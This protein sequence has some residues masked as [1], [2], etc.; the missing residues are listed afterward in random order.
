M[1][2]KIQ[3]PEWFLPYLE[4]K[5]YKG[6]KGGRGSG[7]SHG[8]ADLAVEEMVIDP[9][10]CFVCIREIQKSLKFSAKKLVESK[11]INHGVSH[12]FDVT[13]TEIRRIGGE[14]IMIFQGMQDHTSDSIK[15]LEGFHRAWVEEAQSL[16]ARSVE[17]L[18]PTIREDGSEVWFS[19][20]PDQETDPVEKH[21]KT[22]DDDMLLRHINY[23]DNPFLPDTLRKEME[24]FRRIDPDRFGH[25]WLGEYNTKKDSL[26]FNNKYVIDEFETDESF[27]R[28]YF[29]AD[30]G[31]SQDP[32]TMIKC[33]I[34]NNCLYITDEVWAI[35]CEITDTPE[36]FD[37]IPESRRY[38]IRA[39][40]ARPE[41]ISHVRRN[42]FD[43]I[44]AKKWKGSVED[45]I[46][47]L[48]G[49]DKIIIHP[50]CRKTAE[51]FGL[52]SYKIDRLTGDILPDII[53]KHN[54]CID[55]IRY[56][57][58]PLVARKGSGGFYSL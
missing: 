52:Y 17:L 10:L 54:H 18:L 13:Q 48:R 58:E 53:D 56:A 45:G 36:L 11:I 35:G 6:I 21:F 26:V 20:N 24:R 2:I 30:W 3:T 46:A 25:V 42:N 33:Y 44:G 16:S 32:T 55:A 49:F 57:I 4:P 7:K 47:H 29:G 31:F 37:K 14:G 51:E 1:Q 8:F 34:K 9:D 43:I 28:P 39:D 23:Y 22:L 15:S 38:R 12:L 41:T 27:G 19:W 40:C 5:R 50:R